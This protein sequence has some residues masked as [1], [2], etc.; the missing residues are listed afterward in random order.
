VSDAPY[1]A[2]DVVWVTKFD[3]A[4]QDQFDKI[5]SIRVPRCCTVTDCAWDRTPDP[6]DGRWVTYLRIE[7]APEW[8]LLAFEENLRPATVV[9]RLA[10]LA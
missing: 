8:D 6:Y 4:V 1:T 9:E 10:D 3:G 7:S 5:G 2:G